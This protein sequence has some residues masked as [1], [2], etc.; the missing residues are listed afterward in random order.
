VGTRGGETSWGRRARQALVLFYRWQYQTVD[1]DGKAVFGNWARSARLHREIDQGKG[2][3]IISLV[4]GTSGE[5]VVTR[6]GA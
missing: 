5:M 1:T 6:V 4:V 3:G 2:V